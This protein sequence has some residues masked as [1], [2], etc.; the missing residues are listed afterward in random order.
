MN[1]LKLNFSRNNKR[2]AEFCIEKCRKELNNEHLVWCNFINEESDYRYN[3]ILN[4]NLQEKVGT[5]KQIQKNEEIRKEE[6][7]EK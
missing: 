6:R 3:D 7:K 4:G 5:L 2:E 1:P